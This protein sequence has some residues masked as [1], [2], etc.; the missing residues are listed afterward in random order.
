MVSRQLTFSTAL[1]VNLTGVLCAGLLL[2]VPA[3][4]DAASLVTRSFDCDAYTPAFPTHVTIEV[5]PDPAVV[6][7]ALE[8]QPP[9]GWTVGQI[10][11]G[12]VYDSVNHKV[13]WGPFFDAEPRAL[14]YEATPPAGQTGLVTF[15]GVLSTSEEEIVAIGGADTLDLDTT[16]PTI[17]CPPAPA[18][19]PADANC[20]ATVPDLASEAEASDNC[21]PDVTITQTPLAGT[22][23]GLGST[24]VTLTATD[25]AGNTSS[26]TVTVS[27]TNAPPIISE[28]PGPLSL[29]VLADSSCPTADNQ[30]VLTATDAN[31]DPSTLSWNLSTPPSLGS[32]SFVGGSEGASVTV[33]YEPAPGQVSPDTFAVRV[34]DPCGSTDEV[35]I[36]VSVYLLHHP[37]D[38]NLDWQ[39]E[40]TEMTTYAT[41]W[42]VSCTW[43]QEPNPVPIEYMT[44][45]AYLWQIGEVYHYNPQF[46]P[47]LCWEPGSAQAPAQNS[48][49]LKTVEANSVN[50]KSRASG[51]TELAADRRIETDPR[52]PGSYKVVLQVTPQADTLAW[53]AEEHLPDGWSAS[54][55]DDEAHYDATQH[56]LKWG[57]FLDGSPQT[58]TYRIA[59][60]D[61]DPT[62][63]G[64]IAGVAS[65]NGWNQPITGDDSVKWLEPPISRVPRLGWPCGLGV[66]QTLLVAPA[67]FVALRR[68]PTPR[69][70]QAGN[71]VR[72]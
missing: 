2:I 5:A 14:S 27:V 62:A 67:L 59:P 22:S 66:T 52:V 34:T 29:E 57:P 32:V 65:A 12:G 26:C 33:C 35:T 19:M 56:Q 15:D 68:W 43:P 23:I 39:I 41:C 4:A 70:V 10:N 47:P 71:P 21:D 38:T 17:I 69:R 58:L 1:P 55:L 42:Q 30:L 3:R 51:W 24:V 53:A 8:D 7:Y 60:D 64:Q 36:E 25:N 40:I 37:A 63:D 46:D 44:R 28:G 18:P 6:V 49:S 13:K 31:H 50:P 61:T 20:Q 9:V 54:M 48:T 16:P 45:A 11:E 72:R